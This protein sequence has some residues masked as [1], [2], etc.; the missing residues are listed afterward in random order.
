MK[1]GSRQVILMAEDDADDRLLVQDALAEC[2]WGGELRF[3]EDGED[4][5]NYLRQRGKHST[6]GCAPQPGLVLLDLNLPKMDG[7]EALRELK[8]HEELRRI[9]VVVLTTSKA[10][11]DVGRMYDLGANSFISKPVHFEALVRVLRSLAEYW[12]NTVE[13]PVEV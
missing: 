10:A 13:L 11:S 9:P 8:A 5:L 6:P 3:V 7:R 12:F 2:G 1:N 4:L